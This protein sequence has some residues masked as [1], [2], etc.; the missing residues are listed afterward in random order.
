[1]QFMTMGD[2]LRHAWFLGVSFVEK[3]MVLRGMWCHR[4]DRGF[5]SYLRKSTKSLLLPFNPEVSLR[6]V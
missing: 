2:G 5:K 1:M 3:G 4:F 6:S